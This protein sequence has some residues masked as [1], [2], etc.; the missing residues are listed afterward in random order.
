MGKKKIIA[1]IAS[2]VGLTAFLFVFFF[3]SYEHHDQY[4]TVCPLQRHITIRGFGPFK[5]HTEEEIYNNMNDRFVQINGPC[6]QHLWHSY[7]GRKITLSSKT[8]YSS[9][10][11]H[12]FFWF[13]ADEDILSGLE[14]RDVG[15]YRD[16]VNFIVKLRGLEYGD[17]KIEIHNK[18]KERAKKLLIDDNY[19][20]FINWWK[21]F[22]ESQP[23]GV[24]VLR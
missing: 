21:V 1:L 10:F 23:L 13:I 16:Y 15:T 5:I 6:P 17:E 11:G 7:H 18:L 4:C 20:D 2:V 24:T 22:S 3:K 9:S 19:D 8:T 12:S 14:D